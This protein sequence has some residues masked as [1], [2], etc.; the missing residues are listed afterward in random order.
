MSLRLV[1]RWVAVGAPY[2]WFNF[3]TRFAAKE[4]TGVDFFKKFAR[5]VH[6][7]FHGRGT[8][9]GLMESFASLKW[10]HFDPAKVHT[11]IRDF[12]EHT[13]RFDMS[14]DI[15]WNPFI[16]PFGAW[17]LRHVARSMQQLQV[18]LESSGFEGLDN[19]LETIDLEGD[20]KPDFRCWIRVLRGSRTPVYVGAYKTYQS[21]T[22]GTQ[23]AYVTVAFPV[24]GGNIA[25]VLT[26][27]NLEEH[28]FMLTTR[29]PSSSENGVYWITPHK[30]SF[31]MIPAFGLS[32]QFQLRLNK[33]ENGINVIHDCFWLSIRAFQMRYSIVP[34]KPRERASVQGLFERTEIKN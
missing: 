22:D 5:R 32:E 29:D 21:Q 34:M 28:G 19:W 1:M 11:L 20:E 4:V 8:D 10:G 16:R 7:T 17:Y 23:R 27:L 18:P 13:S 2:S 26:P 24:P 9:T 25:T 30:R 12:Y 6:A 3:A 33:E 14:I 15:D 31:S